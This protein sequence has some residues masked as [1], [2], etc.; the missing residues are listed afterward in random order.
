MKN[1]IM[2]TTGSVIFWIFLLSAT[3]YS[4][5]KICN[6]CNK[7]ISGEYTNV[8][9]KS[10]H[11]DHFKCT[12]CNKPI[13]G[14]YNKHNSNY[15]HPVCYQDKFVE[16]CAQCG[17]PVKG[18]YYTQNG[19]KY[20]EK[21][22]VDNFALACDVCGHPLTGKFMV[23]I[24]SNRYHP[25]HERELPHCNNC[26]RLICKGITN[27]GVK[28]SDGRNICK[29]CTKSA[30]RGD[31]EINKIFNRVVN[32]LLQL[33]ISITQQNVTV[34]AADRNLLRKVAAEKYNN[35]M[36]GFCN[37][38]VLTTTNG[39]NVTEER[40]HKVYILDKIPYEYL[41]STMAHEIMHI[42]I[43]QNTTIKHTLKLEEGSCN[44]ISYLYMKRKSGKTAE[45]IVKNIEEDSSPIYG[46][47]FRTVQK[48]FK[49][50]SLE[51]LLHYLKHNSQI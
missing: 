40:S 48:R 8:D 27:G 11:P 43:A 32:N 37:T 14:H 12:T 3:L 39:N 51:S 34:F 26:N 6:Y 20:H 36:R 13:E 46:V 21:C 1:N 38:T 25:I 50:K 35:S 31:G 45:Y 29:I 10:F 23:D 22:F 28:Y 15:Y 16:K 47:G 41:E 44:Y 19:K 30:V 18:K 17:Q 9:G 49:Y 5:S 7:T 4:Q 33:G 2:K 24:Y 42:W